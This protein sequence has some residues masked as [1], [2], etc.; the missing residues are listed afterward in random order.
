MEGKAKNKELKK[1]ILEEEKA[2]TKKKQKAKKQEE[3]EEDME[4]LKRLL[5]EMGNKT[6]TDSQETDTPINDSAVDEVAAG[7]EMEQ[8]D[9]DLL[10]EFVQSFL[11]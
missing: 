7:K 2:N 9:I 10:E 11:A 4:M 8:S 1:V 6:R 5:R 3:S